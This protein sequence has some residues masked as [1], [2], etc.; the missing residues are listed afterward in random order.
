MV[1]KMLKWARRY[2]DN[3]ILVHCSAGRGRTGT[4]IAAFNIAET[5]LSISETLYPTM[6]SAVFGQFGQDNRQEPDPYYLP[7]EGDFSSNS[8]QKANYSN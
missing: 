3:R 4:L 2:R 1:K 6:G 8:S 5:L 7:R